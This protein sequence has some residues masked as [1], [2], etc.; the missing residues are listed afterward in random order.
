M[1]PLFYVSRAVLAFHVAPFSP[2]KRQVRFL[3]TTMKLV[4]VS[5]H[6]PTQEQISLAE[7]KG[8]QLV[9]VGDVDAFDAAAVAALLAP[10]KDAAVCAVHPAV[11]FAA[12]QHGHTVL[13]VFEN[14]NR[15]PEGAKPSFYAKSLHVW[16]IQGRDMCSGGYADIS[17]MKY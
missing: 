17:V 5:R 14:G 4:F 7:A 16:D 10:H 1:V 8:F 11:F 9:H 3:E 15:A 6:A 12:I 2:L 13:G